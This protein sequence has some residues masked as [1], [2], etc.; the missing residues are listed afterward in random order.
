M[1]DV[2]EVRTEQPSSNEWTQERV[3]LLIEYRNAGIKRRL[4][5]GLI[6]E[7][8]GSSYTLGAIVGKIDRTFPAA[9]PRLSPEEK[10]ATKQR[11]REQEIARKRAIRARTKR[12][13]ADPNRIQ[14]VKVSV[15]FKCREVE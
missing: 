13:H 8:T 15:P 9:R 7:A 11:H 5:A 1:T 3:D 14:A 10:L 12:T 2:F 4:I 6:N